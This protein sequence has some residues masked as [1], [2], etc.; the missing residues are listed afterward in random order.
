[1]WKSATLFYWQRRHC[2]LR[3]ICF[4]WHRW[5]ICDDYDD[6]FSFD[7]GCTDD[8]YDN[9]ADYDDGCTYDDYDNCA[10]DDD[11]CTYDDYDCCTYDDYDWCDYFDDGCAD[12]D[13]G[14]AHNYSKSIDNNGEEYY[15]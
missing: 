8:D 9:C 10:D 2:W 1:M 15:L 6:D 4:C 5:A 3:A 12:D 13:D 11:G 7:D 14:C